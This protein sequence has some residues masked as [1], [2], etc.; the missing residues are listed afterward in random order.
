MVELYMCW[1]SKSWCDGR[2]S[3]V[4]QQKHDYGQNLKDI[5][6]WCAA[7][8]QWEQSINNDSGSNEPE[9]DS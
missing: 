8:W 1:V 2:N 9:H 4:K 6:I 7:S 3:D 5:R